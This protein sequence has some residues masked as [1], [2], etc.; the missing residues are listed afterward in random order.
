M[1]EEFCLHSLSQS[2]KNLIPEECF[3]Q[4]SNSV[5]INCC[6]IATENVAINFPTERCILISLN[7]PL[8]SFIQQTF[9]ECSVCASHCAISTG[10][11]NGESKL[12]LVT[13]VFR[14]WGEGRR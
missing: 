9:I 2:M 1:Y 13:F 6:G 4:I 14:L 8:H 3:S 10:K 11:Y 12:G 7:L 5:K